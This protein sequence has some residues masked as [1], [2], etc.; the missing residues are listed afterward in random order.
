MKLTKEQNQEV[1]KLLVQLLELNRGWAA[2]FQSAFQKESA[3]LGDGGEFEV[4]KEEMR[5]T[6]HDLYHK[7]LRACGIEGQLPPSSPLETHL[8]NQRSLL[9]AACVLARR[10]RIARLTT[11]QARRVQKAVATAPNNI[12]FIVANCA[13]YLHQEYGLEE[14]WKLFGFDGKVGFEEMLTVSQES[15]D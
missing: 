6:T 2:D 3:Q 4:R 5:A 7:V 8:N 10:K 11:E 12:N 13:N 1:S 15:S 9:C 14:P